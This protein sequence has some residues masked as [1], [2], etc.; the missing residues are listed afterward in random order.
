MRFITLEGFG[1]A[2]ALV[3]QGVLLFELVRRK[4]GR[5]YPILVSYMIFNLVEDPLGWMLHSGANHMAYT[6]FYYA[7]TV[8]DYLLQL[9]ILFE[10]GWN[11]VR[12]A[13][14]SIPFPIL[15][16]A[17]VSLLTCAVIAASF[18]GQ[19]QAAD[20]GHFEQVSMRI[21]LGLAILKLLLFAALA[22][23]AQ[24]L[25]IGWK[26]HVLQLATGL[27]FYAA[28]SLLVQLGS[29]H[30][31]QSDRS[32]YISHM[33]QL[34]WIQIGAYLGTLVFWTWAF[35]RNEAPRKE[36]TPQMQQVLVTIAQSAKR[37]RL[38]VTR[39]TDHR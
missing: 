32:A 30:L 16:V 8:I 14:R 7:V 4:Y 34:N 22:G 9:F 2:A 35:S 25:G 20:I 5:I 18:S 3:L 38:A 11:V 10:I 23:F 1:V 6:R 24:M 28:I 29:S 13:R 12:P 17:V 27:A 37:T 21:M 31:S 19:V 39:T 36:F 15:P 33:V 26:N